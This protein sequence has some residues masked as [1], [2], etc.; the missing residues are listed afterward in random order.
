ML[1]SSIVSNDEGFVGPDQ[2]AVD[3]RHAIPTHLRRES[4]LLWCIGAAFG[5]AM[6]LLLLGM[7]IAEMSIHRS[8]ADAGLRPDSV[9]S[10]YSIVAAH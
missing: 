5:A 3:P 4:M 6:L 10:T 8:S 2:P 1:N 7:I 9:P